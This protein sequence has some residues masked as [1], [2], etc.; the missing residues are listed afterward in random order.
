MNNNKRNQSPIYDNWVQRAI[1]DQT[2]RG[3]FLANKSFA[4]FDWI[5]LLSKHILNNQKM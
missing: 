3:F 2:L 5:H 4:V 1:I